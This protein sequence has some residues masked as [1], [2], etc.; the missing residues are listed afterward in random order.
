MWLT[1]YDIIMQ[2]LYTPGELGERW[3]GMYSRMYQQPV[4]DPLPERWDFANG[5]SPISGR[6]HYT[7]GAALR[8]FTREV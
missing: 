2:R 1:A 3:L 4:M 5:I 7:L 8:D 6:L